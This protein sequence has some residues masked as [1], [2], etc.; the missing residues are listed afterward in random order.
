[1]AKNKVRTK[2]QSLLCI[3]VRKLI[4]VICRFYVQSESSG[5]TLVSMGWQSPCKCVALF[6]VYSRLLARYQ[7]LLI[8]CKA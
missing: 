3:M 4:K 6:V 5:H 7:S 2:V 1:M 8:C